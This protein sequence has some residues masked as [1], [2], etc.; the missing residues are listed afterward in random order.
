[1][2]NGWQHC[3]YDVSCVRT[4]NIIIGPLS[5]RAAIAKVRYRK[6]R[7]CHV[8]YKL[9]YPGIRVKTA[10]PVSVRVSFSF[11]FTVLHVSCGLLL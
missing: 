7:Y 4:G 11:S 10:P 8:T 5:Q 3:S 2:R 9:L 1:M 6:S